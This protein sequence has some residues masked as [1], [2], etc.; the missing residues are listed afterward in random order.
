[1]NSAPFSFVS[2]AS[3]TSPVVAFGIGGSGLRRLERYRRQ[4]PPHRRARGGPVGNVLAEMMH[5]TAIEFDKRLNVLTK[6]GLNIAPSSRVK[7]PRIAESP[8]PFE[9][10]RLVTVEVPWIA[11]WC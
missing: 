8:V 4:R 9:C 11:R 5:N 7:P 1:M 2:A 3:G 10:E 6:S